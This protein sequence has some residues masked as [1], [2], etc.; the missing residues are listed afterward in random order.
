MRGGARPRLINLCVPGFIPVEIGELTLDSFQIFL[1]QL[2]GDN[3]DVVH[4]IHSVLYV[5]DIRV[6]VYVC[7]SVCVCAWES[8]CVCMNIHTYTH[9]SVDINGGVSR[10]QEC[11]C[12]CMRGSVCIYEYTYIHTHLCR[13]V[14]CLDVVHRVHLVLHVHDFRISFS[15]CEWERVCTY[16]YIQTYTHMSACINGGQSRCHHPIHSVLK[17]HIVGDYAHIYIIYWSCCGLHVKILIMYFHICTHAYIFT[18]A[19]M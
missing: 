10:C 14:V 8:V 3:L 12:V 15:L 18:Y 19:W 5:H 13:H 17:V 1:T 2:V 9:I 16:I 6:C 11:V 4:R 7:K